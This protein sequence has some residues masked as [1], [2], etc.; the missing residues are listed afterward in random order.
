MTRWRSF[1]SFASFAPL[2]P[3]TVAL[4]LA[5]LSAGCDRRMT[6]G[7]PAVHSG[8]DPQTQAAAAA[9]QAAAPGVAAPRFEAPPAPPASPVTGHPRL[10]V[11]AADLP[12]LR[13]RATPANPMFK[14]LAAVAAEAAA[15][16][17]KGSIPSEGDCESSRVYCE[18]HAELFAFMSLVSSDEAARNDYAARARKIL[19]HIV[20]RVNKGDP[21]DPFNHPKFS[22]GDRARWAGESF[23]LTVDWIYG[24]LSPQDKA[25]IRP[26]FLRWAE[27]QLRSSTTSHDHPEPAGKLNDPALLKEPR[28]RRYAVN[29]YFTSHMRN[30]ALLSLAFDEADDPPAPN[31]KGTYPRLRDY[32]ANVTGAWLYMTDSVLRNDARGGAPPEGFQ[33]GPATLAY[34][35]QTLLAIQ[36]AGEADPAKW[37]PQVH[38]DGNPFWHEFI[39]AHLH[40]LSP[41]A[42]AGRIGPTH[43][44]AWTGDGQRYEYTDHIDP[45]AALGLHAQNGGNAERLNA[46]RWMAIHAG[47]G[48]AAGLARRARSQ[49]GQVHKRHSILYFLL[50]DPSV[51]PTDPRP[52][53]PLT[54]YGPGM[55]QVFARTSWG[56]EAAW[57]QF[58]LG[59]EH[60]D[61]Q[62]GDGLSFGFYRGGEWLTKERI[63]YGAFFGNSEQHNTLAVEND[64]NRRHDDP[65]RGGLWQRGSQWPLVHT[66]DPRV[67]AKSFAQ[68]YVYVLGDATPLYNS[69][70]E[71]IHDVTHVS[72]SLVWLKPDHLVIYDRAATGKE[73]RF[74]RFFLQTPSAAQI[75][76]KLATVTTPKG[77]KLFVTALLPESAV[78]VAEPYKPT[79]TWD[80]KPAEFEPMLAT[81]RTEPPAPMPKDARFL[82]VI[83]GAAAGAAAQP[84]TLVRTKQGTPYAGAAV[85]GTLV[86]FPVALGPVSQVQLTSLPGVTRHL[87]TGLTPGASYD[88]IRKPASGGDEITIRPGSGDKATKADEGG[89]LAL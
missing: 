64:R 33:Y 17:D 34:V 1:A 48:G 54:H 53:V 21:K 88:V 41:A 24:Y 72:R 13:A 56:P 68:D 43:E 7:P 38:L 45:F 14:E 66:H 20:D 86:L 2:A 26:V 8:A 87:V 55:G 6:P 5:G 70:Y 47:P 67:L 44:A 61:H 36:T 80:T 84:A 57:F 65:N 73:G 79:G 83:E 63:G 10:W 50:L 25:A 27:E 3:V 59:W 4:G 9:V 76:G 77:Q 74:K 42:P 40:S 32:F 89:V 81:L 37:G 16:M 58:Q 35:T 52:S 19:L 51:T 46:L 71:D 29:N 28:K 82:H 39:P 78:L 62:H 60:I 11:R 85:K 31:H 30:L 22:T 69:D 12:K 49:L 18:A 75:A 23:G 15:A